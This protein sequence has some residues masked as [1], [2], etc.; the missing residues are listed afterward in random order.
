M[1]F[2]RLGALFKL[3]RV[4]AVGMND[5]ILLTTDRFCAA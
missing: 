4:W 2:N 1:Q 3:I 5:G